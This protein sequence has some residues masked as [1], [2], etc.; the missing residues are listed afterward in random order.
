MDFPTTDEPWV[1][2]PF[3][4]QILKKKRPSSFLKK[5]AIDMHENGY[6][7]I[8][9]KL[10]E[11][12]ITNINED[13]SQA[14]SENS[15]KKNPQIYHYNKSPRIVEAW[16]FSKKISN[17]ANNKHLKSVLKF[18]YNAKPLPFSTI[19]FIA[20]TEQPFHS[21]SIHFGSMP[22][23]YLVGAW[24]ALESTNKDNGPLAVIPKSH[25][26]PLMSYQSLKLKTP[27]TMKELE[28]CYRVY[29][30]FIQNLIKV[31]KLKIKELHIK[32][33]QTILWSANLLHGG[34]KLRK[35]NL[36]R[37]SQVTH[38]HFGNCDFYYNP[39]FSETKKGLYIK[40]KLDVVR[41]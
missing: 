36:T 34:T 19:N 20:G 9:L 14:I 33:G 12:L 23:K 35:K 16:K 4:Y 5:I 27:T 17:L 29:E 1:E 8:D 39:G 37:K 22:E 30:K 11:N 24:V 3:F 28:K 21:D 26:F 7:I 18:L 15:I 38:F 6:C 31:K 25:K 40:R 32:K 13:I 41:G 10:T 2:S